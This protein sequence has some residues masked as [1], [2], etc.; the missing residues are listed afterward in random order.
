MSSTRKIPCY[1]MVEDRHATGEAGGGDRT[2]LDG[3]GDA[4]ADVSSGGMEL[5]QDPCRHDHA[6][7]E[8]VALC[9]GC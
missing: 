3:E 5:D 8:A 4:A 7:E 9:C 1:P 2:E 6:A